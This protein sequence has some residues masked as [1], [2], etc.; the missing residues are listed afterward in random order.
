MNDNRPIAILFSTPF[1]NLRIQL[2]KA[3]FFLSELF[4]ASCVSVRDPMM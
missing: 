1:A 2:I 3:Q 4:V